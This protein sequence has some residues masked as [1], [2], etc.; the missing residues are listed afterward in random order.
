LAYDM[1]SKSI[2]EKPNNRLDQM[3]NK[4]GVFCIGGCRH[5]SAISFGIKIKWINGMNEDKSNSGEAKLR[6][7]KARFF[8]PE[9]SLRFVK[10]VCGVVIGFWIIMIVIA[11]PE[12]VGKYQDIIKNIPSGSARSAALWSLAK[13]VVG[14]LLILPAGILFISPWLFGLSPEYMFLNSQFG[15]LFQV[16]IFKLKGNKRKHNKRKLPNN[17]LDDDRE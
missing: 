9:V 16:V 2:E 15:N 17:R 6:K 13:S 12:I 3:A 7:T 1:G 14:Y 10:W 11:V 5:W 8:E 4:L